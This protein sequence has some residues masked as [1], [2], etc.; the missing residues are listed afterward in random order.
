MTIL[1][2]EASVGWYCQ[3]GVSNHT[4]ADAERCLGVSL[5][6]ASR[7]PL[8]ATTPGKM[9]AAWPAEGASPGL[10]ESSHGWI[11]T[12]LSWASW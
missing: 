2:P 4:E 1:K 8:A 3:E 11:V 7:L 6:L 12:D 10:R 9:T 5:A